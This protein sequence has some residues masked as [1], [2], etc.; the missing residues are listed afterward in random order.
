MHSY[1]SGVKAEQVETDDKFKTQMGNLMR[2]YLKYERGEGGERQRG[3]EERRKGR[4]AKGYEEEEGGKT[5][6]SHTV[7]TIGKQKCLLDLK[8]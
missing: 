6:E 1:K 5:R 3:R 8:S 4:E 2:V 7:I